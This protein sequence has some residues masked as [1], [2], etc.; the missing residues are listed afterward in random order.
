VQLVPSVTT[1]P[2][3]VAVCKC[4]SAGPV[5]TTVARLFLV[6]CGLNFATPDP[7]VLATRWLAVAA[8]AEAPLPVM[9]R[10]CVVERHSTG[11]LQLVGPPLYSLEGQLLSGP[12]DQ[13]GNAR[14]DLFPVFTDPLPRP[15]C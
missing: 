9:F 1:P 3:Y 15:T 7:F 8:A 5:N 10:P 4:S 13:D 14:D 2:V 12:T 6:A 11:E